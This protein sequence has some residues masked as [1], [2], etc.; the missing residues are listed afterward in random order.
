MN[1]FVDADG[2]LACEITVDTPRGER[3]AFLYIL[4]KHQASDYVDDIGGDRTFYWWIEAYIV[5]S[6]ENSLPFGDIQLSVP[7]WEWGI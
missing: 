1:W 5:P 2:D 3:S 7:N 4:T 6:I